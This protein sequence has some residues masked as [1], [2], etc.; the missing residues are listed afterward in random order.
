MGKF[1][2]ESGWLS[3][4]KKGEELCGDRVECVNLDDRL[5]G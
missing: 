1:Y 3:L 4:T 2:M 5:H